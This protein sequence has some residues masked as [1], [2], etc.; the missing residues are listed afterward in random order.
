MKI[1]IDKSG[2]SKIST[3][4][5]ESVND[6]KSEIKKFETVIDGINNAWEGADALKFVNK[7]KDSY[8]RKLYDLVSEL[9]KSSEYLKNIPEAY[10]L[11]DEIYSNK[12][13]NV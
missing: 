5:N 3:Q 2:V 1:V 11:L 4:M 6:F 12:N 10:S 7:L 8:V 9:E 13:I